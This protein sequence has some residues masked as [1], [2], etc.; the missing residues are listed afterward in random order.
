MNYP[1]IF[2]ICIAP[3][4]YLPAVFSDRSN[5]SLTACEFGFLSFFHPAAQ[6]FVCL[7]CVVCAVLASSSFPSPLQTSLGCSWFVL[8]YS[9]SSGCRAKFGPAACVC[10]DLERGLM[11]AGRRRMIRIDPLQTQSECRLNVL[12]LYLQQPPSCSPP[13]PHTYRHYMHTCTSHLKLTD[14]P[15]QDCWHKC[16]TSL[17]VILAL[18]IPACTVLLFFLSACHQSPSLSPFTFPPLS[19]VTLVF[20]FIPS[21]CCFLINK[22]MT[23]LCWEVKFFFSFMS[24]SCTSLFAHN[25]LSC[26][27]SFLSFA[28]RPQV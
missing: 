20:Y 27:F 21:S 9:L 17:C 1:V 3:L 19:D 24:M 14:L 25:R 5:H 15:L 28:A 23:L 26:F 16:S 11:L 6:C 22:Q 2:S 10:G 13:T 12:L 8:R 18:H 4:L 7:G